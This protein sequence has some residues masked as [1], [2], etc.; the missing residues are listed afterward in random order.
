ML[1]VGG[2]FYMIEDP[3]DGQWAK[4]SDNRGLPLHSNMDM[5][6]DIKVMK[7]QTF[8]HFTHTITCGKAIV[9]DV[10]GGYLEYCTSMTR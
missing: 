5:A 7:A 2:V 8:S 6:V 1:C 9:T 4:Y 3:L 10:Q